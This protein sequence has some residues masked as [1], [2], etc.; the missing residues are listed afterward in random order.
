[1]RRPVLL[2]CLILAG[3]IGMDRCAAARQYEA[4]V[5][6]VDDGDSV[7]VRFT[8]GET[9]RVRLL[10]IDAPEIAHGDAPGQEP[11]GTKARQHLHQR[12]LGQR[13]RLETGSRER[14][15]YGR[16]LAYVYV[17]DRCINE[18]LVVQGLAVA[19][20][21]EDKADISRRISLA[22]RTA[23]ARAIGIWQRHGGLKELPGDYRRRYR[24]GDWLK[25]FEP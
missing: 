24:E 5:V 22:E 13:V 3:W 2:G 17:G 6:Q 14:D 16:L 7:V 15:R 19:Y 8:Q 11:W 18:E 4:L 20:V 9:S 25:P 21:G 23:R 10:G 12:L 1:M